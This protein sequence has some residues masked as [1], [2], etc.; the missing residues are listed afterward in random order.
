MATLDFT[1]ERR[2]ELAKDVSKAEGLAEGLATGHAEGRM[3]LTFELVQKGK[4]TIAEGA[5]ELNITIDDF[6]AKMSAAGF[7]VPT[8]VS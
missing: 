6:I 1:F 8:T 4:L 7:D 5:A 2:I 3:M